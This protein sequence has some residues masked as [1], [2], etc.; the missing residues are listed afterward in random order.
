MPKVK[1][2]SAETKKGSLWSRPW[3][4]SLSCHQLLAVVSDCRTIIFNC[5]TCHMIGCIEWIKSDT[6]VIGRKK[7][8]SLTAVKSLSGH[9]RK[10]LNGLDQRL[11]F[12][13]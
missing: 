9:E 12:F 11:S 2:Q 10:I 8:T 7:I 5:C 4:M 6:L 1:V 3:R 13:G